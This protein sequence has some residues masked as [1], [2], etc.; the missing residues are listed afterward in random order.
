MYLGC[1]ASLSF[2]PPN[3][4][5]WDFGSSQEVPGR[6]HISGSVEQ[7][8]IFDTSSHPIVRDSLLESFQGSFSASSGVADAFWV[9]FQV[10][11]G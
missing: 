10:V 8:Y 7:N 9:S 2:P 11:R 4:P 5:E 1:L 3:T 6:P